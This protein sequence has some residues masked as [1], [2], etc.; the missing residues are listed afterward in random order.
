[1]NKQTKRR[2]RNIPVIDVQK[3]LILVIKKKEQIKCQNA[4]I[5]EEN[6]AKGGKEI[7]T[8]IY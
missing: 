5:E 4:K 6:K 2:R 1:M 7:N 3:Q 8:K